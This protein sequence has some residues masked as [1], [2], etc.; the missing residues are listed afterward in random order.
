MKSVALPWFPISFDASL[1][2]YV[3]FHDDLGSFLHPQH[4]HI[5]LTAQ[6]YGSR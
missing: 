4:A 1:N 2:T 3:I 5:Q 6:I